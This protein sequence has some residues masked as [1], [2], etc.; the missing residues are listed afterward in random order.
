M[1][2]RETLT[3]SIMNA[4]CI[5]LFLYVFEGKTMLFSFML[6]GRTFNVQFGGNVA[7]L[8]VLSIL[9]VILAIFIVIHRSNLDMRRLLAAVLTGEVGSLFGL[10]AFIFGIAYIGWITD[11]LRE[12][13]PFY[14]LIS[15]E[16]LLINIGVFVLLLE[17]R[18]VKPPSEKDEPEPKRVLIFALSRPSLIP[19][20]KDHKEIKNLPRRV[21]CTLWEIE[22]GKLEEQKSEGSQRSENLTSSDDNRKPKKSGQRLNWEV[23]LRSV[24]HHMDRLERIYVLVSNE[25][26][27]E[28]FEEGVLYFLRSRG[29]KVKVER[30]RHLDFDDYSE[31][32]AALL[33]LIAKVKRDGYSDEDFSFNISGGTSAVTAALIIAAIKEGRQVEYITQTGGPALKRID[34]NEVQVN[35]FLGRLGMG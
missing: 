35:M 2:L 22:L 4:S 11:Y 26:R 24:V 13:E 23:P 27:Y 7:A 14:A 30:T 5:L 33:N 12:R 20:P 21:I 29:K 34:V 15:F 28:E 6:A 25:S 18:E 17:G 31:I 8:S 10:V 19:P 32:L 1:R 9:I 3:L 16:L